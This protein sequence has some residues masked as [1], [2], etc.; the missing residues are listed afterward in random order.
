MDFDGQFARTSTLAEQQHTVKPTDCWCYINDIFEQLSARWG[1]GG[2][3][4]YDAYKKREREKARE[5]E[6]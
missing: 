2:K 1:K 6:G 5:L 4:K 3:H